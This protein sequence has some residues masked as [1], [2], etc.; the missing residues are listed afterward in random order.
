MENKQTKKEIT[1]DAGLDFDALE[2]LRDS[3]KKYIDEEEDRKH[4]GV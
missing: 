3:I 4:L 2:R 1:W